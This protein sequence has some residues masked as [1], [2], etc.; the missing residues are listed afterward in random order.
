[1]L[2]WRRE[3][4]LHSFLKRKDCINGVKSQGNLAGD[5]REDSQWELVL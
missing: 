1:M 4:H 5:R 3:Q 2:Q